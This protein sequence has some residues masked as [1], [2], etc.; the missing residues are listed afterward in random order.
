LH[1]LKSLNRSL[2]FM[3]SSAF[4]LFLSIVITLYS[5]VNFYIYHRAM[6]AIPVGNTWRTIFPILFWTL[7]F[8]YIFAR[9]LERVKPC[10]FTEVMT[11]IGS[12]WLG[13]MVYGFLTVL[14]IDLARV[15]NSFIHYF[16]QLFYIDYPK[17][18]LITLFISTILIVITVTAG[19][20]NARLPMIRQL[21]LTINKKIKGESSLKIVMA[22]DIHMGTLIA[23]RRTNFLVDRINSLKP[24]LVLFAGDLVDEDLAP[25][26]RRNLGA[27]LNQIRAKY[28][29]FGITGNH[30]YIGGAEPAVKYLT[31]H[32]VIMLR[33]S[34]VLVDD[35]FYIVGRE[36]R[37][38]PRFSGKQRKSLEEVMRG[39]D[40]SYP[41]I[42]MD[43][44]PFDLNKVVEQGVDLQLS[45]H[46]HHGQLWP[47]NY[48]T[49]AIYE[50]SWGY[51]KIGETQFY[52]SSGFGSWGPPV[53]LGNRPEIVVI[54][55]HFK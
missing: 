27:T 44:Q 15:L 1:T 19:F 36:D 13:I 47:F 28:G 23:K 38:R 10:D 6:Q 17:T 14:L 48:I 22:S 7:A 30:E 54:N 12:I 3:K 5:L 43:H 21:D 50:L 52:V 4:I 35:R 20:I 53:R 51:K 33:D 24:D 11:W 2:P 8:A 32:G 46:T 55:I 25:V 31:E 45:G 41:V 29:V 9:F 42:L 18:K 40:R 34:V 49:N 37:D 16:P 39:V 26:I